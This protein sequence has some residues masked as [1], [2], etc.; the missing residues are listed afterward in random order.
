[1]DHD[2]IPVGRIWDRR[3][4][5]ALF[6]A[7]GAAVIVS[8]CGGGD[9]DDPTETATSQP[10][11]DA[12]TPASTRTAT[13]P[14]ASSTTAGATTVVPNCVATPEL[15]EGPYFVD[16]MLDRSDIRSDPQTGAVSEGAELLLAFNVFAVT[17]STCAPIQDA[18]VDVWHCD[19]AG[20][21]SG[22]SDPGF[23]TQGQKFLRGFQRTDEGGH[24]EFTTVYPGW[25]QGRAV[26]IHFKVRGTNDAGQDYEFTSQLFFDEAM[27]DV[28]H[29]EQP[30][31]EKGKRTLL[32]EGD[33]IYRESGGQTLVEVTESGGKYA[34]TFDLGV[35]LS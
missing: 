13:Q 17:G 14:A 8:A 27:T 2:D 25:Y 16:E 22:V 5:L 26:H 32:N 28:V 29:A 3:D 31:A 11:E 24:V 21:Y 4:V 15:T 20:V 9:G 30:Y 12:T 35:Q 1:M 33:N 6:G 7:A 10:S 18:M 23:N 19:A 34:G